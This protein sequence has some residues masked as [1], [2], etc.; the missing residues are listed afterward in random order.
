M[1]ILIVLAVIVVA[2]FFA[3]YFQV[4]RVNKLEKEKAE[5]KWDFIDREYLLYLQSH[6]EPVKKTEKLWLK[7]KTDYE[8]WSETAVLYYNAAGLFIETDD[9]K[10]FPKEKFIMGKDRHAKFCPVEELFFHSI[11]SPYTDQVVLHLKSKAS[12]EKPDYTLTIDKAP[13]ELFNGLKLALG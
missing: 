9:I 6:K 11:E 13:P 12:R 7:Y 10:N 1:I 2:I 3:Y 4:K 8:T 5:G